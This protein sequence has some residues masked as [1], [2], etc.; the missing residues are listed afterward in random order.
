MLLPLLSSFA[1][2]AGALAPEVLWAEW[3]E[4]RFVKAAAPCLRPADLVQAVESL[5]AQHPELRVEE[6]GTSALSR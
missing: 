5:R 6:V 1:F 3:P 2:A 4:R